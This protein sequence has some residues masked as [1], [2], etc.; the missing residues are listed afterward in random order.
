M[1]RGIVAEFLPMS[2]LRL[3]QMM[4]SRWSIASRCRRSHRYRMH[5]EGTRR[6]TPTVATMETGAGLGPCFCLRLSGPGA[7]R[8][9]TLLGA[10]DHNRRPSAQSRRTHGST[11]EWGGATH[12]RRRRRYRHRSPRRTSPERS[13]SG[14]RSGSRRMYARSVTV[15][16][17][18]RADNARPCVPKW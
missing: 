5:R 8:P 3:R 10:E 12:Q 15:L 17:G 18:G 7:A 14:H 11:I 4:D 13:R 6:R 1:L 9:E 16:S 2:I